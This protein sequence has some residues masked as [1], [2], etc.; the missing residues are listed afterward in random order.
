M[1]EIDFSS[2]A[3]RP[4]L[5]RFRP[6]RTSDDAWST[7]AFFEGVL[8]SIIVAIPVWALAVIWALP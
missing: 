5:P 2:A 3:P 6:V 1:F 7:G 4:G 8:L